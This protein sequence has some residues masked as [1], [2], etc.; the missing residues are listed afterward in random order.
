MFKKR[1][2]IIRTSLIFLFCFVISSSIIVA[3]EY[4]IDLSVISEDGTNQFYPGEIIKLKVSITE[5][6]QQ[7]QD[8]VPIKIENSFNEIIQEETIQSKE[9][10]EITLSSDAL[11]NNARI[12]ASYKGVEDSEDIVIMGNKLLDIRIVDEKLVVTNTGNT[13]Y[14]KTINIKIGDSISSKNPKLSIGESI[15]YRLIAPEGEYQIIV[16]DEERN[17][18]F[19]KGEVRLTG[20]GNVVGAL[21]DQTTRSPVTGGV[22]PDE[23][24]DLALLD[25]VKNN[26]FTY[27]FILTIFGAMILIAI[28]RKFRKVK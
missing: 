15:S 7:I 23:E 6:G 11:E 28:E 13:V 25:Y 4:N 19:K 10:A 21:D 9:I 3:Q 1:E 18:L 27:V 24:D 5:N 8:S 20:T 14:D 17:V 16:T 22:S 12:I 26:K 2:K